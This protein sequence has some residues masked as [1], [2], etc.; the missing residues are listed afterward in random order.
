MAGAQLVDAHHHV[1]DLA[2]RDQPW[3]A[4]LARLRRS[5][6]FDDLEPQLREC[7]VGSTVVVQ[8]VCVAEETPELLELAA[9]QASSRER[10]AGAGA[11]RVA[12]VVGW[13]DLTAPDVLGDLERLKD[14]PGG[15]RLVGVRHQVQEEPDPRWLC[16]PE[17]RRGLRAVGEAGLAYDLVVRAHQLPAVTETVAELESVRFILDHIGKPPIAS[18]L[19]DPWAAHVKVLSALPNVAVKLSGMV[20]EADHARWSPADL[21][22]YADVVVGHFGPDRV[23]WGS[24]WPVCLLAASYKQVL[25]ASERMVAGLSSSEKDEV[26]G[27]TA[28]RWYRL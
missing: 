10:G 19:I 23:M 1:W 26:F 25:S 22:P 4:G 3:T 18:G 28:I 9:T 14:L 13:V 21:Q 24:D 7:G 11:P 8:T 12:G 27:G 17:V 6:C 15:D 5:F 2:V 20:T 16:R